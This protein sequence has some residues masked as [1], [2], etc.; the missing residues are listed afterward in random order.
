MTKNEFKEK[1]LGEFLE[2]YPEV[3]KKYI[4]NYRLIKRVSNGITDVKFTHYILAV[5][6][7]MPLPDGKIFLYIP[8]DRIKVGEIE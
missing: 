1:A 2:E 7:K 3:D 6:T 5:E 4:W 8:K